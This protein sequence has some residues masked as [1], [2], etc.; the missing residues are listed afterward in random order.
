MEAK[1]TALGKLLE[2]TVRSNVDFTKKIEDLR[3]KTLA[4]YL[5]ILEDKNQDLIDISRKIERRLKAWAHQD[6][7]LKLV[8]NQDEDKAVKVEEPFAK[9][10][11]GEPGF[12]GNLTNFGH[13]LQRAFLLALLQELSRN[14]SD[15][16]PQ[17]ILA[18]EEP[19]LYQHPPQARHLYYVLRNL[20][21]S[22]PDPHGVQVLISTHS[23][24]FVSGQ[25]FE[26][27]RMVRKCD[28]L[29]TVSRATLDEVSKKISDAQGKDEIPPS[30]RL[31]QLQQ[32]LQ[33]ERSEMFFSSK[34]IFV[35]GLEDVS[36]LTTYLHLMDLWGLYRSH[37]CHVIPMGG[38]RE[39]MQPLAVATCLKIPFFVV[40]DAD[41][42]E[43]NY[44]KRKLHRKDNLAILRLCGIEDPVDFP[45]EIIWRDHVVVWPDNIR[46]IVEKEIGKS[47]WAGF[48]QAANIRYGITGKQ[49][50]NMLYIAHALA[51][52]WDKGKKSSSLSSLCE[53]IIGFVGSND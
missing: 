4:E 40:F 13:G 27:V 31:A 48:E 22:E 38:K 11:L 23:P 33:P 47:D 44:E 32:A 15:E 2:R 28:G 26:S 20:T 7:T 17:L 5:K 10:Q 19:E 53:K 3:N 42:D 24:Y 34:L 1:T 9:A 37:G 16:E 6:T 21:K 18:C 36:Y 29:S 45:A 51:S 25:D 46:K 14:N 49:H 43:K 41:G 30:S 12:E 50:K 8:W 35:E 52:A 39:M